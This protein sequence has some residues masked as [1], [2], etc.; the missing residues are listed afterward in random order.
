M[1]HE[2]AFAFAERV[3]ELGLVVPRDDVVEPRLAAKL[4][5]PLRDLVARGVPKTGE[6]GEELLP[7][8]RGRV[9]AEDDGL[10]GGHGHLGKGDRIR[11]VGYAREA[12]AGKMES[13]EASE[14]E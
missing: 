4:V 9:V 8:G 7:E 14:S 11:L 1:C 5:Y 3:R 12:Y 2:L 6:E 10:E 13:E